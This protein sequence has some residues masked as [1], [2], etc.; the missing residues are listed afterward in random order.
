MNTK[1]IYAL[2]PNGDSAFS[3]AY[4]NGKEEGIFKK[5]YPNGQLIEIR[6]YIDGNKEGFHRGWWENGIRKFE[7]HFQVIL[8]TIEFFHLI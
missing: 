8:K 5:W 3:G 6:V 7:Y 1:A 4:L 2:Y